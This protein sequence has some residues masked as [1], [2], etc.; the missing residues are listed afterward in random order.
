MAIRDGGKAARELLGGIEKVDNRNLPEIAAQIQQ[1]KFDENDERDKKILRKIYDEI[2]GRQYSEEES[3]L[4]MSTL[5]QMSEFSSICLGKLL[6]SREEIIKNNYDEWVKSGKD[7]DRKP[8]YKSI[9]G[10]L[11]YHHRTL[12]ISSTRAYY[13]MDLIKRYSI[14]DIVEL[15]VKKV[16]AST[17]IKDD[18]IR[19]AVLVKAQAEDWDSDR[20]RAVSQTIKEAEKLNDK[21]EKKSIVN[22]LLERS[23]PDEVQE[24]VEEI[25]SIVTIQNQVKDREKEKILKKY[26]FD[27]E[28]SEN[29]DK[30]IIITAKSKK[31]RDY[32]NEALL[33]YEK[34]LKNYVIKRGEDKG[35]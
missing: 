7:A 5:N 32:F 6:V 1:L 20:I 24:K 30:Q 18:E 26:T 23:E 29:D 14:D 3:R 34:L 9:N 17:V 13:C 27:I 12:G 8:L 31:Q 35:A 33:F 15:G 2:T 11:D 25:K 21:K 28:L 22:A 16:I 19:H 4:M 10:Y